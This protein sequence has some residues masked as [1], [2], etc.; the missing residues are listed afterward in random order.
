MP[1]GMSDKLYELDRAGITDRHFI[2]T[3]ESRDEVDGVIA[4][5]QNGTALD[6]KVRRI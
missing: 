4:A 3:V 2:F 1:T 5:Y 6:E